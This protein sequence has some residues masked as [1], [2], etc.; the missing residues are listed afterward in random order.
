MRPWSEREW[1][2]K[3]DRVLRQLQR[4]RNIKEGKFDTKRVWVEPYPVKAHEVGGHWRVITIK[5]E[6]KRRKRRKRR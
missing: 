2:T 4:L 3:L 1:Q 5:P 6:T